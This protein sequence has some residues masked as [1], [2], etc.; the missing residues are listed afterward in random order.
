MS[1]NPVIVYGASGYTGRLVAEYLRELNVP[2]TA[3][4]RNEK[5][6]QDVMDKL[7]GRETAQLD[8]S[9]VKHDKASL[10]KLFKGAKVVC[11]MVGP[12]ISYGPDVVEACLEAGCHYLDTTGEQDWVLMCKESGATPLRRRAC[13]WRPAS[14][15]CTPPA[16]SP[17]RSRS[18][19]RSRHA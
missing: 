15:R 19:P 18:K 2:F 10:V 8:V 5:L 17:R 11:N 3:V 14:R 16:R 13:F 12:F 6:V 7:P 4:G 9:S 1:K